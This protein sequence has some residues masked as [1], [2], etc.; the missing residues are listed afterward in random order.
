MKRQLRLAAIASVLALSG[1]GMAHAQQAPR[2]GLYI[3]AAGG[4]ANY[5]ASFS[6]DNSTGFK[7]VVGLDIGKY[8][9]VELGY[10]DFGSAGFRLNGQSGTIQVSGAIVSFV[11][12]LPVSDSFSLHAKAGY[13]GGTA[14][15]TGPRGTFENYGS[16]PSYGVGARYMFTKNFGATLEYDVVGTSDPLSLGSLGVVWKF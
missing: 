6:V 11:G 4:S 9:G 13:M 8:M 16:D 1:I 3:A 2:N 14:K 10:I 12:R 5:D 7:A 15:A